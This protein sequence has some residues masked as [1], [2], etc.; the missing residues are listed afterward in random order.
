MTDYGGTSWYADNATPVKYMTTYDTL[1]GAYSLLRKFQ[2]SPTFIA[3]GQITTAS[4]YIRECPQRF[5]GI[6][7]PFVQNQ[8]KYQASVPLDVQKRQSSLIISSPIRQLNLDNL[9]LLA[10]LHPAEYA[11]YWAAISGFVP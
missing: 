11:S 9:L 10:L 2:I 5:G 4:I 7:L 6:V 1:P 8:P 3:K